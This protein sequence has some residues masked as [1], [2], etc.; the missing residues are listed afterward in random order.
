[1]KRKTL[2]LSTSLLLTGAV[3]PVIAA[4]PVSDAFERLDVNADGYLSVSEAA[5]HT[6][7]LD[8]FSAVDTDADGQISKGEWSEAHKRSE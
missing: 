6:G 7:L 2:Q 5:N 8:K 1:M 3:W 4:S